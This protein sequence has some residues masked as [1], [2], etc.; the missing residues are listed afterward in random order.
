MFAIVIMTDFIPITEA[1]ETR[2]GAF[3]GVVVKQ[4]D[5]KS[6]TNNGD[7]WSR[8]IFTLE[9][10]SGQI[11][12]TAWSEEIQFFELGQFYEVE[13]LWWKEYKGKW[14]ANIGQYC[15]I[16]KLDNPPT[17]STMEPS[18]PQT[19]TQKQE[20]RGEL[21]GDQMPEFEN[22]EWVRKEALE[23]LQTRNIVEEVMSK[24]KSKVFSV[25]PEALLRYTL[26]IYRYNQ[27][28]KKEVQ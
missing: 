19:T 27:H 9:D 8:K 24:Y 28:Y 6:G 17:Q 22:A 7:D 23:L 3:K 10:Q 2:K 26:E 18:E 15:K 12:I 5:L 21:K 11:E 25:D 4:S 20:T 1:I 16:T 14:G 13:S